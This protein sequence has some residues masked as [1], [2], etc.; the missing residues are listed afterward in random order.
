MPTAAPKQTG[1]SIQVSP[2][3]LRA[4]L[5]VRPDQN[6][7]PITRDDILNLMKEIKLPSTPELVKH[8]DEIVASF[9]K[10]LPKEPVLL[11]EGTAPKEPID[12]SFVWNENFRQQSAA[13]GDDEAG[14]SFYERHKIVTVETGTALGEIHP[15][16]P[17]QDGVDIF[18][19]E[20][21]PSHTPHS[22]KL[23]ENVEINSDKRTLKSTATG[24][25]II[26][27]DR[28]SVHNVIDVAHNVDF[29]TGN[30]DSAISVCVRGNV[31]DLFRVHSKQHI[32]VQGMVEAAFLQAD[33][34]ISIVGGIKGRG[35]ALLEAGGDISVKFANAI[36]IDAKGK[37]TICKEAIDSVVLAG[38][39][40][41]IRFGSLIGGHAFALKGA[42][43]KSIGSPGGVKTIVGVGMTPLI[44]K[45]IFE[46]E[47]SMKKAK[48]LIVKIQTSVEP[49]LKERKRMTPEQREKA[50]ELMFKSQE[51]QLQVD[52]QKKESEALAASLPPY[53]E[54]EL[55][56]SGRILPKTQIFIADRYV[57]IQEEIKGPVK[58]VLRQVQGV[59]ELLLVNQLTGSVRSLIAGRI[60]P[61]T[62][63]EVLAM[64]AKPEVK[65][66]GSKSTT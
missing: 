41:D 47:Q 43:A 59:K 54:V 11:V 33:G 28:I 42:R 58:V 22:I 60:E 10:G 5:V 29:E 63:A 18:G 3:R 44:Y 14:V 45:R 7:A 39:V 21:K 48:D 12:A 31:C 62:A 16:V 9:L 35:K 38:D 49:L 23:G 40:L 65:Q 57:T 46:I 55:F 24:Q 15:P 30:I 25:V 13:P 4:F 8:I 52:D 50:T 27:D 2:D 20:I 56:V 32:T 53:S 1:L 17:G 64:P 36:Y 37:V 66:P 26:E 61:E 6:R 19:K 51:M 34:D